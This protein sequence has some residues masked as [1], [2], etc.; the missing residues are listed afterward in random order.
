MQSP[1]S[2][3]LIVL[4]L[5]MSLK[6]PK[7][8]AGN[9]AYKAKRVHAPRTI[10]DLREVVL[11]SSSLKVQGTRHCFNDIADSKEDL[12][13]MENFR[14]IGVDVRA[15]RCLLRSASDI[16]ARSCIFQH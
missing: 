1:E 9:Y 4:T 7:N 2:K 8:W 10:A 3:I 5:N 11:R 14:M 16:G 12:I 13:S 15:A 6:N